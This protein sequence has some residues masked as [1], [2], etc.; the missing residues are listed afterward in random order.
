MRE[1]TSIERLALSSDLVRSATHC[2]ARQQ[3]SIARY[4]D[5]VR[6]E[7]AAEGSLQTVELELR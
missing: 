5:L 2:A 4:M 3:I 6:N 7:A 1:V